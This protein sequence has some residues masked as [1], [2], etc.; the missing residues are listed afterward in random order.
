MK[1]MIFFIVIACIFSGCASQNLNKPTSECEKTQSTT[2]CKIQN[3]KIPNTFLANLICKECESATSTL[4]LN[5]NKSFQI[6]TVLNKKNV[7]KIVETGL[8]SIDGDILTLTNQ[9]REK[10]KYR[11][12]GINLIR[13]ESK[14]IFVKEPIWQKVIYRP[15]EDKHSN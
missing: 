14:D 6:K 12:D 7:Q 8:F 15:L 13:I 4:T 11:F 5:E 10:S 9:Y 2:T 1:R 3:I